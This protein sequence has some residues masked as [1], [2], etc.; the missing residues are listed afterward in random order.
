M[1]ISAIVKYFNVF[2]LNHFLNNIVRFFESTISN[3]I[4]FEYFN[5]HSKTQTITACLKFWGYRTLKLQKAPFYKIVY[6]LVL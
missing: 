6:G 1:S 4:Q 3:H 2:H 5:K